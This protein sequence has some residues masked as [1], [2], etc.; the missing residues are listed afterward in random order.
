MPKAPGLQQPQTLGNPM[1]PTKP[2]LQLNTKTSICTLASR[3]VLRRVGLAE[4]LRLNNL[5][6]PDPS[7][8]HRGHGAVFRFQGPFYCSCLLAVVCVLVRTL[9]EHRK[10]DVSRIPNYSCLSSHLNDHEDNTYIYIYIYDRETFRDYLP[11]LFLS[12]IYIGFK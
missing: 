9:S 10:K 6:C 5:R 7:V 8:P 3:P 12:L 4:H 1:K 2:N 11:S